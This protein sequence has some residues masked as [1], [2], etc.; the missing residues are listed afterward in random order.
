MLLRV[1]L[2]T[3]G[4]LEACIAYIIGVKRVG[5]VGT[6][7]AVTSIVFL[8]SMLRLLVAA[9][10]ASS[11]LIL[12]TSIMVA[13]RCSETSVLIRATRRTIIEDGSLQHNFSLW[14]E[15]LITINWSSG[16]M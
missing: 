6:M 15:V 5:E 3:T 7:L 1:V 16:D 2:V 14:V 9:N 8:R 13:I 10:V 11:S 4:V 12:V